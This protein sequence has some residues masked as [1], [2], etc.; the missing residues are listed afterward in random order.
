MNYKRPVM[1]KNLS[2]TIAFWLISLLAFVSS[3]A[4]TL[5]GST[6]ARR[7][8]YQLWS[9]P[10][11]KVYI[12]TNMD[13]YI[14]GDTIR[15]R[16]FLVDAATNRTVLNSSQ[17]IYVDLINPFGQ[18][19]DRIKLK[20]H[21]G[22]FAG[23][24]AIDE[25]LPEGV[26]TLGAYT[27]F[28]ENPGGDYFFR[29]PISIVSNLSRKYDLQTEIKSGELYAALHEKGGGPVRAENVVA[30][31]SFENPVFQ[32]RRLSDFKVK[33]KKRMI[34]AGVIKVK[35]DRYEKFVTLPVD[36]ALFSLQFY[37]EGGYLIP[38][39]DNK[40]AFK[41]TDSHGHG[42]DVH[43]TIVDISGDTVCDFSSEHQGM[44][45]V[46]F[47]PKSG[48]EYRA[49]VGE[50]NFPFPKTNERAA[51]INVENLAPDSIAVRIAGV[52]DDNSFLLAHNCGAVKFVE[53]LNPTEPE[54]I[55]DKNNLGSGIVQFLLVDRYG[56]TLSSRM[57]FCHSDYIY[58]A[59]ASTSVPDGDYSVR[60]F[61]GKIPFRRPECSIVSYLLL[62]SELK[63]HIENSDYYFQDID[64][65]KLRHMDILMMTHGW[66]RYNIPEAMNGKISTPVEPMEIGGEITGT[67][68]SRWASKLLE[69]A[70]VLLVAPS[71]GFTDIAYSD[72]LGRFS[73]NGFDW[74]DGTKFAFT[75]Y[76]KNGKREHNFTIDKDSFPS[77]PPLMPK[78]SVMSYSPVYASPILDA[79]LLDEIQVTAP[80]SMEKS[81]QEM[82][83]AL[84]IRTITASDM[85]SKHI[86][87]YEEVIYNIPGLRIVN[88][89][90]VSTSVRNSIYNR[91]VK[92]QMVELW[93]DGVQ[94][95]PG[96][97]KSSGSMLPKYDKYI[98]FGNAMPTTTT[99]TESLANTLNEFAASYP[100]DMVESIQY[101]RSSSALIISST[102]ANGAGALVITTKKGFED[103]KTNSQ[104]IFIQTV[105]PKGYQD[106]AESFDNHFIY[107]TTSHG[108]EEIVH[109]WYP[110]VTNPDTIHYPQDHSIIIEGISNNLPV[111][112]H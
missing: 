45:M 47:T 102:A 31:D 50:R 28:M 88:G 79:I 74:P 76:N 23:L 49:I 63:G 39:A 77:V 95:I 99:Y 91:S 46:S 92:N 85:A 7:I 71:I 37:P 1:F 81:R 78:Q 70:S 59:N 18:V 56:N 35:F 105:M 83:S 93:V 106:A 9:H 89:N 68:R 104:N 12:T 19:A 87:T 36:T 51:V 67:V 10:Q 62:D 101:L 86:S 44:G 84:G 52:L 40:V 4:N 3:G 61:S 73:F 110:F 94:W 48:G 108:D 27:Q 60:T 111:F 80:M 20:S 65:T 66:E 100:L 109:G 98:Q 42:V 107:E 55:L 16:A 34:D 112:L 2:A 26:Y 41:A 17:Y 69:G 8:A 11:E 22:V 82:L 43:G 30:Y 14:S 58:A 103:K 75:V 15:L 38:D 13:G 72:S 64:S 25:G 33:L 90:I 5:S 57:I 29:K 97:G 96:F 53:T 24:I 32:A 6:L 54:L 21:N